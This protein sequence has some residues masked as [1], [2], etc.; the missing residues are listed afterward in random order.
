MSKIVRLRCVG[1]PWP[2]C[3]GQMLSFARRTAGGYPHMPLC[4]AIPLLKGV[5]LLIAS[6]YNERAMLT[7]SDASEKS[8]FASSDCPPRRALVALPRVSAT[9]SGESAFAFASQPVR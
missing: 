6:G 3:D 5:T 4:K 1:L 8:Q 7:V 2:H 9:I